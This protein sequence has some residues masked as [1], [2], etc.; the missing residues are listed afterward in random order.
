MGSG[1]I[2]TVDIW[3]RPYF[4][5]AALFI[6][7]MLP[8]I[9]HVQAKPLHS[10]A[11][12]SDW[13]QLTP[14]PNLTWTPCFENFT[15]SR[16]Q[17]PLNYTDPSAGGPGQSGVSDILESAP[18]YLQR[19]GSGY[20]WVGFD[21]RGVNNSG[22]T[23][24][25]FPQ[26]ETSRSTFESLFFSQVTDASST[27]LAEQYYSASLYGQWCSESFRHGN[28]SGLHISTPAV[29]QDMLMF[30]KAEQRFK[31]K[32]EDEAKVWYY[33]A[34]YGTV[35]GVTFAAL[36]PQNAGRIILDGVVD[37]QDYY[38]GRWRANL[39]DTDA[40]FASFPKLCYQA[41]QRNCSFWGPSE[42]NITDRMDEIIS[43]I[44]QHP[45]AVSGLQQDGSSMGLTTYS[46]LKQGMLYGVYFPTQNFPVLADIFAS[47]EAGDGSLISD[48]DTS[49][50]WGPDVNVLIKCV[51][52][53]G[54]NNF[55]SLD[56]YK[57]YVEILTNQSKSF[58][59]AW[60]NN[61]APILCDSLDLNIPRGG[62]FPGLSTIPPS[63][64][65]TS[66]QVVF[67]KGP[68]PP[69]SNHTTIPLLFLS[70]SLDPV[71]PIRGAH[72][73]SSGF[74]GSAVLIQGD[75]LGHTVW[76]NGGSTCLWDHVRDYLESG[77]V[78]PAN[79]TCQGA[80]VPFRDS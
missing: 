5:V 39:Y 59:T 41:G 27:S 23:V 46:D 51:D 71:S 7:Q 64:V 24:D 56:E 30:A 49:L 42:K 12:I 65:A 14:S 60:P 73:M 66:D 78:P 21:P 13:N 20:T 80:P 11:M 34:S 45:L 67:R 61:A 77:K 17:V 4:A 44:K 47:V 28:T 63:F 31:G 75:G 25:C 50:L 69:S 35:L 37:A 36:Y 74:A 70:N 1:N 29:A 48:I 68:L 2:I 52:A 32:P 54:N 33:G 9:C 6:S 40:V 18:E 79:T 53:Y 19:F 57:A 26:N 8:N 62:S 10:K 38:A 72:K 58:G 43:N 22:P 15:C 55:T 76:A 3:R 16:L